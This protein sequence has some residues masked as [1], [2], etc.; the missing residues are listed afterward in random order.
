MWLGSSLFFLV[1]DRFGLTQRVAPFPDAIQVRVKPLDQL[2]QH[3]HD[4]FQEVFPRLDHL[5]SRK[6]LR[7][8]RIQTRCTFKG[9]F[10]R[11]IKKFRSLF[12][13][14]SSISFGGIQ[15]RRKAR[16]VK[17]VGEFAFIY[18]RRYTGKLDQE[19]RCPTEEPQV[20]LINVEFFVVEHVS[21]FQRLMPWRRF[22]VEDED[23][24]EYED[25]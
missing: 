22:K 17:L 7:Y 25:D 3:R 24:D 4:A 8:Q 18:R 23:D 20:E 5:G 12:T 15:K 11:I 16:P 10:S 19:F 1:L 9:R 6:L 14:T 21:K 13:L 2:R